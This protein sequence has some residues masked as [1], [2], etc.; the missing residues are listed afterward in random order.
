MECG[1]RSLLVF[2]LGMA[3][4]LAAPAVPAD[5]DAVV[6]RL[7]R[8][9]A[10]ERAELRTV[11]AQLD[12]EP[13]NLPLALTLA[14]RYIAL[15][16]AESDPRFYGYAEGVM[17]PWAG[18]ERSPPDVMVMRATLA[19]HR[20]DFAAAA[21]DLEAA[22]AVDPGN[23]RAWLTLATVD[24]VQGRYASASEAC[25]R[26]F[27]LAPLIVTFTCLADVGS[28]HGQAKANYARLHALY[29]DSDDL[30]PQ[31]RIWTLTVLAESAARAG[32]PVAAEAHFRE[33]LEVGRRDAA[34]LAAY[35]DF[36]F[37]RQRPVA[38]RDLLQKEGR[39]DALLLRLAVAQRMLGDPRWV[40]NKQVLGERIAAG[41]QRGD[42]VHLR[43]E[44][45]FALSLADDPATALSLA[46][47][48]WR[49][50]REPAD[51]RLV[52]EAALA[53]KQPAA[54]A[55]VLSWLAETG[56]EDAHL[57]GLARQVGE[58]PA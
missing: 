16:R 57:T 43:E 9:V 26:L 5:D 6:E 31:V 41:R 36:L 24:R 56:L 12:R 47:E 27:R 1:H 22:I 14:E 49:V 21:V 11:R 52:L 18:G 40:E 58:M 33:A 7:P 39:A 32:D 3:P 28:L 54:A 34:L 15:G 44:A 48:N 10:G 13:G 4:A 20:H 45:R 53:A 29:Q 23:A 17:R 51:A 50:Q 37:D 46:G 2:V 25:S 35:A 8:A 42:R 19:Q 38:V 55:P 30:D